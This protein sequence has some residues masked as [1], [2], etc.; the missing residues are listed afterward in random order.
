MR[1]S[2]SDVQIVRGQKNDWCNLLDLIMVYQMYIYVYIYIYNYT[3]IY[4]HIYI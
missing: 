3:Y 2:F 1:L 4:I